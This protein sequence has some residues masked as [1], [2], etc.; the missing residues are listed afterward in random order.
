MIHGR[1]F[2]AGNNHLADDEA[3]KYLYFLWQVLDFGLERGGNN[4][5]PLFHPPRS[6]SFRSRCRGH[7]LRHDGEC[8]RF[9]FC[10]QFQTDESQPLPPPAMVG[11]L[12]LVAGL[13]TSASPSTSALVGWSGIPWKTEYVFNYTSK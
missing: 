9:G 13:K 4:K 3:E 7:I 11:V 5:P 6:V 10:Q 1:V 12:L 2:F 8:S